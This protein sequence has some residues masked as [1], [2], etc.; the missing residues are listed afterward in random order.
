V[1]RRYAPV[2][3]LVLVF[4][5]VFLLGGTGRRCSGTAEADGTAKTLEFYLRIAAAKRVRRTSTAANLANRFGREVALKLAVVG[6]D[7]E[8]RAGVLRDYEGDVPV[9]GDE[10]ILAAG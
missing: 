1:R 5:L 8:R 7:R 6:A 9:V 4:T 2:L 3:I 10:P